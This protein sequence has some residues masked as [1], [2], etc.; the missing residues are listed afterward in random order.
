MS[1]V[2]P[3]CVTVK[4]KKGKRNNIVMFLFLLSRLYIYII[5]GCGRGG[6]IGASALTL[7]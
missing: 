6:T 7:I 1:P 2:A 3:L 5:R 4:P